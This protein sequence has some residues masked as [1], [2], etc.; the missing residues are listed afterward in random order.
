[1][2]SLCS[3]KPDRG[4]HHPLRREQQQFWTWNNPAQPCSVVQMC[5]HRTQW[6]ERLIFV[7]QC[8]FYMQLQ[9]KANAYSGKTDCAFRYRLMCIMGGER[10]S[11]KK[12]KTTTLCQLG[13][14]FPALTPSFSLGRNQFATECCLTFIREK[15]LWYL[16]FYTISEVNL[17]T[18]DLVVEVKLSRI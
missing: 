15:H 12:D 11:S 6:K 1:M 14:D 9:M 4:R 5:T 13:V 16:I 17:S 8:D 2:E 18:P 10:C 3:Q 7:I